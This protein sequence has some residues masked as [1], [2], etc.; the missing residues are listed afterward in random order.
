M[1]RSSEALNTLVE[2]NNGALLKHLSNLALV[3][4][5]YSVNSLEY[6]PRIIFQ[7]LVAEAQTTVLLVDIENYNVDACT[8]LSELR[9]MLNLLGPRKVADV[10]KTV[11]TFLKLYEY[12][13]VGEVSYLSIVLASYRILHFDCLPWIFLQ[14][15]DA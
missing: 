2:R 6:I 11:N 9:R 14:L 10:D 8:Y 3:N 5:A 4:T 15:L 7:L 12:T 1:L 13:E